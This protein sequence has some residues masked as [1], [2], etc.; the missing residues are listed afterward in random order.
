MWGWEEW[1]I[2]LS[3]FLHLLAVLCLLEAFPQAQKVKLFL[4]EPEFCLIQ[5]NLPR[6]HRMGTK[7]VNE[8]KL[9]T[10]VSLKGESSSEAR[11][12]Q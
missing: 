5:K 11:S 3:V 12:I 1:Q 9:S 7:G 2:A 10:D 8:S 4:V 6:F